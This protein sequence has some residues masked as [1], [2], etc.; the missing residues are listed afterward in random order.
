M[1][2][3]KTGRVRAAA[4]AARMAGRRRRLAES[5][6][7]G[8]DFGEW[9][10]DFALDPFRMAPGDATPHLRAART[11]FLK[12][13]RS[14]LTRWIDRSE[15]PPRRQPARKRTTRS[16]RTRPR[17]SSTPSSRSRGRRGAQRIRVS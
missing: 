15:H 3:K 7:W 10:D 12:A 11:E 13:L 14:I 17:K 2:A 16:S 1:P 4:S 5:A 8:D 9:F 6:W